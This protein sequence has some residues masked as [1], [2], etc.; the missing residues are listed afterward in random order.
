[1]TA[2]IDN[3]QRLTADFN[4]KADRARQIAKTLRAA[5]K[6]LLKESQKNAA[7]AQENKKL[8][9]ENAALKTGGKHKA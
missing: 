2:L 4:E 9:R 5:R 7:L 6:A 1:V 3:M 8:R